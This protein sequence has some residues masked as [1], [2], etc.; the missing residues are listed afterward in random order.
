MTETLARFARRERGKG[1]CAMH[2][3]LPSTSSLH[4][5]FMQAVLVCIQAN[6]PYPT[7]RFVY[8]VSVNIDNYMS[9]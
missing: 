6:G 7:L 9:S 3:S 8:A 4:H 5:P 2:L 1:E